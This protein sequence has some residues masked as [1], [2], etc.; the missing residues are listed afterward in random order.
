MVGL[1]VAF[2]RFAPFSTR[3]QVGPSASEVDGTVSRSFFR[4]SSARTFSLILSLSLSSAQVFA[5]CLQITNHL[6]LDATEDPHELDF[7]LPSCDDPSDPSIHI[8]ENN[9]DWA[10]IHDTALR[11]FCV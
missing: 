2:S 1:W 7:P 8:I 5:D 3:V 6:P 11:V 10:A 4:S 9:G